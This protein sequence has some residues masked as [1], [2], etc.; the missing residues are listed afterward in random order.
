MNKKII[1]FLS[2]ITTYFILRYTL[3]LIT[4]NTYNENFAKLL[5]IL[6]FNEPY[7]A[8]YNHGNIA[9]S[10]HNYS[11]AIKLYEKA[12]T[13]H[14]PKN[15]ICIIKNNLSI[16]T[17]KNLPKNDDE[18]YDKLLKLKHLLEIDKCNKYEVYNIIIGM[19]NKS[20]STKK[21]IT[22]NNNISTTNRNT[23][24]QLYKNIDKYKYFYGKHWWKMI[25]FI[26]NKGGRL[27]L[28]HLYILLLQKK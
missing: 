12:L 16:S 23:D 3:N 28:Q 17:L 4:I 10:K 15:K 8:Y 27:W 25:Y 21:E 22:S 26:H 11:K 6:N 2:I 24:L 7:I 9:Y 18:R 1:I 13:K 20:T 5:H 19:N 14:P